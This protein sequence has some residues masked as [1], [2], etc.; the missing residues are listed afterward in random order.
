MSDKNFKSININKTCDIE[1][2]V[3]SND[4]N[5]S[6]D[7]LIVFCENNSYQLNVKIIRIIHKELQKLIINS[8][9][10]V[11]EMRINKLLAI[12]NELCLQISDFNKTFMFNHLKD[13]V[14]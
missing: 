8:N 5:S 12:Q 11:F 10:D 7:S 3:F 13:F 14:S 4:L 2:S 6:M 1:E 9:F